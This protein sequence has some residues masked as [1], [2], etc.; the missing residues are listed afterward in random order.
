MQTHIHVPRSD[1]L[2]FLPADQRMNPFISNQIIFSALS[3]NQKNGGSE[4]V[5]IV[6][7]SVSSVGE[8]R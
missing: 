1:W 2:M 8:D 5:I 6:H 7:R 3:E 4:S